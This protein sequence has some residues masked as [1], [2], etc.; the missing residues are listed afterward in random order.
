MSFSLPLPKSLLNFRNGP[1]RHSLPHGLPAFRLYSLCDQQHRTHPA[2]AHHPRLRLWNI[3]YTVRYYAH[4]KPVFV[5]KECVC[6]QWKSGRAFRSKPAVFT[7]WICTQFMQTWFWGSGTRTAKKKKNLTEHNFNSLVEDLLTVDLSCHTLFPFSSNYSA[8]R[9][10]H[11]KA[12]WETNPCVQL[13]RICVWDFC[14]T[15]HIFP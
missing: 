5:L 8:V 14:G 13:S 3:L 2:A 15:K 1:N 12:A 4:Y 9:Q 7:E 10:S 6:V 11:C